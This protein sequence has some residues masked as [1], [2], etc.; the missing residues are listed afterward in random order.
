MDNAI[1]SVMVKIINPLPI[2]SGQNKIYMKLS[3]IQLIF[4][5]ITCIILSTAHIIDFDVWHH[6][7]IGKIIFETKKIPTT[8]L[9][10]YPAAAQVMF[11]PE[12]LFQ[13]LLYLTYTAGG[14]TGIICFKILVLVLAFYC[15][16]RIASLNNLGEFIGI[17]LIFIA[18]LL[19]RFRFFE[20]PEIMGYLFM[21]LL[22]YLVELY[23]KK[24]AIINMLLL[25]PLLILWVNMHLSFILF[26]VILGCF[27]FDIGFSEI[28]IPGITKKEIKTKH[29][30]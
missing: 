13:L 19:A 17:P 29:F 12:W 3:H 30:F 6:L 26:F 2:K 25:I 7:T 14:S 9:L 27:L 23:Q 21:C 28:I 22:F 24:D 8:E 20:R 16:I 5:L 10:V 4:L 15:M 18:I 1:C 11:Y